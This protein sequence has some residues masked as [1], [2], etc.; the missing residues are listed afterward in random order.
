MDARAGHLHAL[1]VTDGTDPL[2]YTRATRFIKLS[3]QKRFCSAAGHATRAVVT[4]A[5]PDGETR[6]LL[7]PLGNGEAVR[8]LPTALQGARSAGTGC[9]DFSNVRHG[10]EVVFGPAD[11]Y[12]AEPEFS[13]GAWRASAVAAGGLSAL[14]EAARAELA[15]RGRAEAPEQRERLGRMFIHAQTAR[16]WVWHAAP[17]AEDAA[18][19]PDYAAATVNLAR[20][21]VEA[22]CMD[23]I[24]LVQRSI[25][26]SA[27]MQSNPVERMCRDLATY[28]R[29]PAPDEALR[30][31]S[32]YFC[33]NPHGTGLP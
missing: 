6:M 23:T 11:S 4:A 33:Q 25:G 10:T 29:Q 3:G 30:Q 2:R 18:R 9:V 21:A 15:G 7:L 13:V 5:G 1:W 16:L 31:A 20:T 26:L 22:A 27:F 32:S 17:I 14:V 28:L 12:L 19:A 24:Q 8:H